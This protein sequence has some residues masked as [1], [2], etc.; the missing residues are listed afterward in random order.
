MSDFA[1]ELSTALDQ[2]RVV[3]AELVARNAALLAAQADLEAER[4]RYQELFELAPVAYLVTDEHG[5][6]VEANRAADELIGVPARRLV[7]KPLTTFLPTGERRTIRSLLLEI[8]YDGRIHE[9]ELRLAPRPGEDVL[10]RAR[11][12]GVVRDG[13]R[14][15][16]RWSLEDVTALPQSELDLRLLA[17]ELETR[18]DSRTAELE[19]ERARLA[20]V[21]ENIP[22]GVVLLEAG[23][24]RVLAANETAVRILGDVGLTDREGYRAD[25]SRYGPDDWPVARSLMTG[26]TVSAERIVLARPDGSHT[27]LESSSAPIPDAEGRTT[28]AVSIFQDVTARERREAAEREFVTNAAHELRTPLAA[29]ASAVEL[30]QSGAK[31]DDE[32]RERFLHHIERESQR[33]QRLVRALLTLARVQTQTEAPRLEIVPL[34]ALLEETVRA[35]EPR[36][37]VPVVVACAPD[38][39]ALAHPDLL[40]R[41]VAN[42]VANAAQ[43]TSEGRIDVAAATVDSDVVELSVADTGRGIVAAERERMFD[44]FFRGSR[45][46]DG[47][48]LGLAIVSEAVRAMDGTIA[49]DANDEGGTVVRVRLRGATVLDR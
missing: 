1:A 7:G 10:V 49:V 17:G 9:R 39:A 2:L 45:D 38:V 43:Y 42:L 47:F 33:L 29:I 36:P 18:V 30:L 6:V 14:R 8:H 32:A 21:V 37:R 4:Q 35:V 34:C 22:A 41:V 40:E 48:G 31:D 46:S 25:G 12:R 26:E 11:V 19:V 27:I 13:V 20:A 23:T 5:A 44:R 3:E 16:L 15:E 28:A 24:R